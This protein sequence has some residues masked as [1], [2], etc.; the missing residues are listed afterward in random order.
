MSIDEQSLGLRPLE[1][2]LRP[3]KPVEQSVRIRKSRAQDDQDENDREREGHVFINVP[4]IAHQ[5]KRL[6]LQADALRDGA[7]VRVA[8]CA[9]DEPRQRFVFLLSPQARRRRAGKDEL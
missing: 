6:C 2:R 5:S 1:P 9:P 3:L 8:D 4:F 7:R